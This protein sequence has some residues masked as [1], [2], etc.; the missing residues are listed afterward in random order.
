MAKDSAGYIVAE[1]VELPGCHT[2]AKTKRELMKRV[3]EAILVYEESANIDKKFVGR[4]SFFG[5]EKITV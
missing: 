2:Q 4:P 1:V 3:K 5:L